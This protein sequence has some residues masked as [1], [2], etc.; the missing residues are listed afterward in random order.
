ME[1][2]GRIKKKLAG[3][4]AKWVI[5]LASMIWVWDAQIHCSEH[6]DIPTESIDCVVERNIKLSEQRSA[7]VDRCFSEVMHLV[8]S[9]SYFRSLLGKTTLL[10]KFSCFVN[11]NL[12]N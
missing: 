10:I 7:A 1:K 3:Q 12:G 8:L 4:K 2:M 11:Y 6:K 9:N 5:H